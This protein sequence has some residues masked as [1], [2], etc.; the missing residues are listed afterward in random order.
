M[1]TE[2]QLK[3]I[4]DILALP[5]P[6][7]NK[8]YTGQPLVCTATHPDVDLLN[9]ELRSE[10]WISYAQFPTFRPRRVYERSLWV[11]RPDDRIAPELYVL[12]TMKFGELKPGTEPFWADGDWTNNVLSNVAVPT[13]ADTSKRILSKYGVRSTTPEYRRIYYSD[14][15]NKARQRTAAR[16]HARRKRAEALDAQRALEAAGVDT[17]ELYRDTLLPDGR[18][19][20]DDDRDTGSV[21]ELLTQ[22]LDSKT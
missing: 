17:K 16:E 5:G 6:G 13:N 9:E 21:K 10:G 1:L 3:T 22:I 11:R 18:K 7:A 20:E 14:P 12:A 2:T 19:G 8:L 15:T 4:D